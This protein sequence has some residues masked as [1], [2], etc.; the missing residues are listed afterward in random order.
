MTHFNEEFYN[1]MV[2]LSLVIRHRGND[3]S[4]GGDRNFAKASLV[5]PDH[6]D[7]PPSLDLKYL[8]AK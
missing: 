6:I 2:D 8:R 3:L 5:E 4:A 7:A 1:F